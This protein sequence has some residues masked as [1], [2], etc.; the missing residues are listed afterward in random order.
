MAN[1]RKTERNQQIMTLW[2]NGRG[3]TQKK[4]ADMF[5]LTEYAVHS[6]IFRERKRREAANVA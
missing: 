2:N 3:P 6:I 4:L 1:R 5:G